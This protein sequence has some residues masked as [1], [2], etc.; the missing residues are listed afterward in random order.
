[1]VN[2][3]RLLSDEA[4]K[5]YYNEYMRRYRYNKRSEWNNTRRKTYN[6]HHRNIITKKEINNIF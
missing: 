3:I 1:M 5:I 4:L 2:D 6:K